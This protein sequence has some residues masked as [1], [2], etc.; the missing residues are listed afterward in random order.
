MLRKLFQDMDG[1]TTEQ[2]RDIESTLEVWEES[3]V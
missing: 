3:S 1:M 2:L